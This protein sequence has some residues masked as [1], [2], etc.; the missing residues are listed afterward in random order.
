MTPE[1]ER[2]EKAA[3]AAEEAAQAQASARLAAELAAVA[4]VLL[5]ALIRKA[6]PDVLR[7]LVRRMLSEIVPSARTA[8]EVARHRG[9]TLGR[10]LAGET[11]RDEPPIP[12]RVLAEVV[13]TIDN[14]AADHLDDA[15]VLS[16]LL[17]MVDEADVMAVVGKA[18]GAVKAQ[19]TAAA[20]VTH[21]SIALGVAEV[22]RE[23][24]RNVVWVA[25]RDACL[26]CLAYAGRVVAPGSP[27][28]PGLTY[29]DKSLPQLGPLLGPPLHPHC[30][31]QLQ[32]TDLEPG[33]LDV[34][35]AREAARSVA[36]G[37]SDFASEPAMFRAADR[38]VKSATTLLPKSVLDRARRNLRDRKFKDRPDSLQAKAEIARRNQA[39]ADAGPQV[40]PAPASPQ[41]KADTRADLK[42]I[43]R[44]DNATVTPLLGGE[45][46]QTDLVTL[47]DGRKAV[48]KT[49]RAGFDEDDT[50]FFLDGEELASLL[51][52]AVGAPIAR[53][54]RQNDGTVWVEYVDGRTETVPSL[55]GSQDGI[56]IGLVDA[57]TAY[58]DRLSGLRDVGGRL[59]GFDNGGSWLQAELHGVTPRPFLGENG[60]APSR[61]VIGPD[62]YRV[63]DLPLAELTAIR[64]RMVKLRPAFHRRG[65]DTW[66]TYSLNVLD[67]LIALRSAHDNDGGNRE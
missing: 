32:L 58:I 52:D 64:E 42:E 17:P 24:K 37:L 41:V 62:G 59:V 14:R 66:L 9:T 5:A 23:R 33:T 51:A 11:G 43:A 45:S 21:R 27:F 12:D 40:R 6:S 57:M 63:V 36:R 48:R 56:R 46:N 4:A 28:P 10:Q 35:L 49:A 38:L 50:R 8:L 18:Q 13:A 29:A 39:R 1:Q 65:R 20:W 15:M 55:I 60:R 2:R 67:Q 54:W 61:N 22:A 7:T 26:H 53:T 31:C 19:K 47:P 3:I 34:G 44:A 16:T 30:R 25:E